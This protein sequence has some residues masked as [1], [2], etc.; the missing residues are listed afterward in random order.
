MAVMTLRQPCLVDDTAAVAS[1]PI[2]AIAYR[3]HGMWVMGGMIYGGYGGC[4]MAHCVAQY[5]GDVQCGHTAMG[6]WRIVPKN[7]RGRG[8]LADLGKELG[9]III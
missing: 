7:R 8:L 4:D 9:D 5:D 2:G 3:C 6:L 1:W